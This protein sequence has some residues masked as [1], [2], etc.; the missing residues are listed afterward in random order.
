MAA[1][2]PDRLILATGISA[3]VVWYALRDLAEKAA[4]LPPGELH[5]TWTDSTA[6]MM[7]ILNDA[8]ANA[9]LS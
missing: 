6:Q 3:G 8:Q 1:N 2:E 4:A 9:K 7:Q 5:D